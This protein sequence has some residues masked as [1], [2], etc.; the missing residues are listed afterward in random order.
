M[1]KD[2]TLYEEAFELKQLG[3]DEPCLK[4]YATEKLVLGLDADNG[5][6]NSKLDQYNPS[7][8]SAPT[9]SQAFRWFRENHQLIHHVYWVY[10][11][12]YD[13]VDWFYQ[14]KGINMINNNVVPH[15]ETR[16]G[17]Y[18]E[19]ELECLKKLIEIVK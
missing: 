4:F 11:K 16:F 5:D 6:T 1:D 12:T 7:Y 10:K 9:Y 15:D 19:A 3:F 13:G 2:F 18:E 17:T 14:I 8:V